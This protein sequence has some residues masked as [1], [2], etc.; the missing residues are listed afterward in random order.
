MSAPLAIY[1]FVPTATLATLLQQQLRQER[2]HLARWPS[3]PELTDAIARDAESVDCLV[4]E[5]TPELQGFLAQLK[6]AGPLLPVVL[7]ETTPQPPPYYHGGEVC[8]HASALGSLPGSIDRAV[9]Q[10]LDLTTTAERPPA[11][12]RQRLARKLRERLDYRRIYYKR[13]PQEFYCHLPASDKVRLR[14]ELAESYRRIV[15][16]YFGDDPKI[17]AAIDRLAERTFFAD[18]SVTTIMEIHMEL[19]EEFAQQLRL[20]GRDEEIL[21]DYRLALIDVIA[22]LS[23]MYRRALPSARC[24]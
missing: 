13:D 23:E 11:D 12:A 15:L 7:L 9:E 18:L 8:L 6:A 20:E 17:N 24:D 2:Y 1:A 16:G 22:H 21:L 5:L 14:A 4:L 19:M 10:F 3:L